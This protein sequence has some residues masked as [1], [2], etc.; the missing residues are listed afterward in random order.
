MFVKVF[1]DFFVL[2]WVNSQRLLFIM[3]FVA[4]RTDFYDIVSEFH[5]IWISRNL[6]F[7][8]S[9]IFRQFS[10]ILRQESFKKTSSRIVTAD[11]SGTW[12]QNTSTLLILLQRLDSLFW[13]QVDGPIPQ[14]SARLDTAGQLSLGARRTD[15]PP[16]LVID[17]VRGGALPGAKGARSE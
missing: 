16:P 17:G 10:F 4:F 15:S 7:L 12:K 1:D 14:P 2:I 13:A 6:N 11:V 3:E 8:S 9:C 5:E